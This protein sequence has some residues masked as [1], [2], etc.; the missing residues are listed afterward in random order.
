MSGRSVTK[1][2]WRF[3]EKLPCDGTAVFPFQFPVWQCMPVRPLKIV[4]F[5]MLG[6]PMRA[7]ER[8]GL[9]LSIKKRLPLEKISYKLSM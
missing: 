6:L 5:P 3:I 4:V 9:F 7:M 1:Y 2:V 8:S